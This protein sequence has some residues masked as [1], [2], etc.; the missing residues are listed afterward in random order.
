MKYL[1][2]VKRRLRASVFDPLVDESGCE[3]LREA[4]TL[5][6]HIKGLGIEA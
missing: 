4:S 6:H 1:F 5:S 3:L 2:L